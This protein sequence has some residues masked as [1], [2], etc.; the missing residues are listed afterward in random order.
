MKLICYRCTTLHKTHEIFDENQLNELLQD[1]KIRFDK[2]FKN[3]LLSINQESFKVLQLRAGIKQ[4]R[5]N[6]K[7]IKVQMIE[8]LAKCNLKFQNRKEKEFE[9][10]KKFNKYWVD[11][12][13]RGFEDCMILREIVV[14]GREYLRRKR[15]FLQAA[16]K[17]PRLLFV[18]GAL[19]VEEIEFKSNSLE[20]KSLPHCYGLEYASVEELRYLHEY[21]NRSSN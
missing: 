1:C 21:S 13:R 6:I 19:D 12:F 15:E 14:K 20:M 18:E 9:D 16:E 2:N 4:S 5:K 8:D 11:I 3:L 7:R 17:D 10:F